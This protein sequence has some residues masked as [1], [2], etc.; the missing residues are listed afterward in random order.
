MALIEI[1]RNPTRHEV[2]QFAC[3]WLPGFL[4]LMG[5]LVWHR[6][7]LSN[8][9]IL[10]G[11]VALLIAALGLSSVSIGR[12]FYLAWMTAVYPIG[13][14]V[15]FLLLAAIYFVVLTPLGL[16]MRV[17]RRRP[18]GLEFNRSAKSYWTPRSDSTRIEKYFRQF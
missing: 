10:L 11:G 7:G 18:L 8:A 14:T 1:N 12:A 13:W 3:L 9:A 4:L 2:R 5:V 6:W 15:S 17:L 16:T